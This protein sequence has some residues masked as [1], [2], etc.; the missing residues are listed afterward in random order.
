MQT[1]NVEEAAEALGRS[2]SNFRRW[3]ANDIIPAP[4]LMD[5]AR[6]VVL[7]CAEE[8]E[9]IGRNLADH[10]SAFANLCSSHTESIT[11]MHQSIHGFRDM[12]FSNPNARR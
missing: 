12:E 11:R 3:I 9:I 8:V 5:S 1:Y 2:L 10:E 4:V 7:Y 6:P